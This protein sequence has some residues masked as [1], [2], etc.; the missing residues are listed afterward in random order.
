MPW[1]SFWQLIHLENNQDTISKLFQWT[2]GCIISF[3]IMW[4][5]AH[6]QFQDWL[7]CLFPWILSL[8]RIASHTQETVLQSHDAVIAIALV[9]SMTNSTRNLT[10]SHL[11]WIQILRNACD[12]CLGKS[13][14]NSGYLWVGLHVRA[15]LAIFT[16]CWWPHSVS[17]SWSERQYPW[18]REKKRVSDKSNAIWHPSW[19][20]DFCWEYGFF[21]ADI[22]LFSPPKEPIK[23]LWMSENEPRKMKVVCML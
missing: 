18:E 22:F 5:I 16:N 21:F 13:T 3:I 7:L 17:R 23:Y 12:L 19:S 20:N 10:A 2:V 8:R 4:M 11:M 6:M 9:G 1:M 15:C 14:V